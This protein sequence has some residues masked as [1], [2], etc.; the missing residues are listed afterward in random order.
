MGFINKKMTCDER[1][2][3]QRSKDLK[4]PHFECNGCFGVYSFAP[5]Q[6][7]VL[8]EHDFSH[9]MNLPILQKWSPELKDVPEEWR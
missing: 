5:R 2:H 4:I 3:S 7:P 1:C 8:K 9:I 6:N